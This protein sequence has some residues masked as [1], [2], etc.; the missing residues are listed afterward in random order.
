MERVRRPGHPVE[1]E[2]P[3]LSD[4]LDKELVSAI[5]GNAELGQIR[6]ILKKYKAHGVPA[7]RVNLLLEEMRCSV[8]NERIED[9]ILETMDI[10]SG[11]CSLSMKVW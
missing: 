3:P 7:S 10:T 1:Q 4:L 5:N 8:S 11:F 6:T 2:T 9:K